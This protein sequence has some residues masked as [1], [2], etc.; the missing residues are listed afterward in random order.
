MGSRRSW[1]VENWILLFLF[2]LAG[3]NF[4]AK[5]FYFVFAAVLV[6]FVLHRKICVDRSIIWYV[7]FTA[8]Y[9]MYAL[10]LGL[11]DTVRKFSFACCYLLGYNTIL[12][13]RGQG[14]L[15]HDE[16]ERWLEAC[17]GSVSIG[18]WIHL[19]LNFLLTRG[20][21][22]T[23]NTI[24]IWSGRV[25]S[26]TGQ[27]ALAVLMLANGIVWFFLP[28]GNM[29]RW[30][31]AGAV[32]S[33][34]L[35][36]LILSGRTLIV[37]AALL[38]FVTILFILA[39]RQFSARQRYDTVKL[40]IVLLV[41]LAVIFAFDVG[42]IR[43]K[44][45]ESNLAERFEDVEATEDL[46]KDGR[47][48]NKMKYLQSVLKYPFGGL[49]MRSEYGYAHD[50]LLDAYDECGIMMFMSLLGIMVGALADAWR[51][52]K[53]TYVTARVKCLIICIY[54]A[55][56]VEFSMEP[57]LAGMPWLFACFALISGCIRGMVCTYE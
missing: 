12:M 23:R 3:M 32:A 10:K 18:S 24:D 31:G 52:L 16:Q 44:L 26:A 50:L 20:A 39:S 33:I 14:A 46:L 40:L 27:A 9:A 28:R 15:R 48:E 37:L 21:I 47:M 41:C 6:H 13:T 35:Y 4:K 2:L 30:I 8:I 19:M 38:L 34:L 56:L 53:N 42:G 45:L 57:I 55:F 36:N 29:M 1:N 49:N 11:M 7:I 54:V 43:S 25:M 22:V 51:T 5:F 17:I